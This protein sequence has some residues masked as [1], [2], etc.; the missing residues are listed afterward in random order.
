MNHVSFNKALLPL[1]GISAFVFIWQIVVWSGRWEENL[2]PSPAGVCS[3]LSELADDGSLWTH[4]GISLYRFA[5]G[6]LLSVAVALPLGLM[7]GWWKP[8][9]RVINP[10]IQLLRPI[11]PIAWFPFIV[12]W[13]GIGNAPAIAIISIAGF[14]PILLAGISSVSKIDPIY[15]KLA[16]NFELSRFQFFYKIALPLAFPYIT[17]GLHIALGAAW[18]FLVA[19]EMIGAQ[20]GLG[21]LIIDARNNIRNDMV[22]AGIVLIGSLG[23][24]LDASIRVLEGY[25]S[26]RW[27]G[28]S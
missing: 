5:C 3:A 21:Y 13:F 11:S 24:M 25:I 6:Y 22:M 10:V 19:G 17:V 20:S 12:L 4:V 23:W 15:I 1:A 18:I 28:I 16:D 9:Q 2:L 27:G 26:R 7:L 14:F 8:A